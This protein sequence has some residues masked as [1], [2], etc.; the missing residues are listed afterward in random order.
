MRRHELKTLIHNKLS[1]LPRLVAMPELS[2]EF[3]RQFAIDQIMVLLHVHVQVIYIFVH[4]GNSY[5]A[6]QVQKCGSIVRAFSQVAEQGIY[7]VHVYTSLYF[8]CPKA[9]DLRNYT[10][11]RLSWY[12]LL[13]LHQTRKPQYSQFCADT[14]D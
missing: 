7:A 3:D 1:L 2:I 8:S 11:A 10:V 13:R 14:T 6:V 5:V 4:L 9:Q 12:V